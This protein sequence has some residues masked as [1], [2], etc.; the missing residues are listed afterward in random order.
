LLLVEPLTD[1]RAVPQP[2]R[3]GFVG[4]LAGPRSLQVLQDY[5]RTIVGENAVTRERVLADCESAVPAARAGFGKALATWNPEPALNAWQGPVKVLAIPANDN[6]HALYRLRRGWPH[7]VVSGAG[8]W[9]QLDRPQVVE[10]AI[11]DVL[12]TLEAKP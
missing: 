4:D 7:Q 5:Y 10:Q 6:E 1:P 11:R 12:A 2:V 8:H 3:D 9:L